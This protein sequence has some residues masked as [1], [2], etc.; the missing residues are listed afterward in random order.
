M[1][2]RNSLS[3]PSRGIGRG[4]NKGTPPGRTLCHASQ[5]RYAAPPNRN[6][7]YAAGTASSTALM[8]AAPASA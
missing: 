4:E 7:S 6:T 3:E 2:M 8:P 1:P 5:P